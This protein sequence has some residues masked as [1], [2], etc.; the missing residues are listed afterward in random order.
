MFQVSIDDEI[1]LR[2]SSAVENFSENYCFD[3]YDSSR[4]IGFWLHMGKWPSHTPFWREQALIF[5]PG[6]GFLLQRNVGLRDST[7]GPS[8][9]LMDIKC[10]EP[11]KRWTIRYLGPARPTTTSE[12]LAA[13][14]VEKPHE[15]LQLDLL[16]EATTPIWDFGQSVK[17]EVWANSHYEQSGRVTGTIKVGSVVHS[18]DGGAHRDH[19]RGPRNQASIKGHCWIHGHFPNG[20]SFALFDLQMLDGDSIRQGVKLATVMDNNHIYPA[21]YGILP[22]LESINDP[23]SHYALTLTSALGTMDIDATI[24][25]SLPISVDKFNDPIYGLAVL[26]SVTSLIAWEQPTKFNW[27]GMVGEGHTE[28]TCN[29]RWNPRR[30]TI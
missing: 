26:P 12:L 10:L 28:R 3:T 5:L 18:I 6:G 15:L 16:F 17:G 30:P 9:A 29:P 2:K 14:M 8:G 19:S 1:P 7:D 21:T 20:R 4:D 23:S 24:L 13:P 27:D 25:R 22:Y 11:G